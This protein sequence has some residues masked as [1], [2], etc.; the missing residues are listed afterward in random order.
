M[1]VKE[2][3][4][5]TSGSLIWLFLYST[6]LFAESPFRID[7][8]VYRDDT[9]APIKRTLTLFSEG[10]YYDFEEA[11]TGLVTVIDPKRNR[12]VLLNRLLQVK[13]TLDTK[14]LQLMVSSARV[15]ADAKIATIT[16]SSFEKLPNG[17]DIAIVRNDF[18]EYRATTHQPL[19]P[20]M[21]QQYAD[22]ADWSARLNAIYQPK[23]PPYL[24]IELNRLIGQQNLLPSEIKRVT[25]QRGSQLELTAR[26]IPIWRLSED[27]LSKV[28][29]CGSMLASFNEISV[30]EYW[31]PS[32][33]KKASPE[34]PTSR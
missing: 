30:D 5:L 18:M 20:D 2:A 19:Q 4:R 15:Q 9:K 22:F 26:L 16:N 3:T 31:S 25:H 13:A 33:V 29:K 17:N 28:N 34:K 21:A 6:I 14:Q 8:D 23:L 27:D 11:E 12:I 1:R 10:V 32:T 24:R 7:T